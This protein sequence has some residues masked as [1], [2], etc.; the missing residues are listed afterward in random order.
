MAAVAGVTSLLSSG[1]HI[2]ASRDIYGGTHRLLT[3]LLAKYRIST[4]FVDSSDP[5]A[6][7]RVIQN[8]TR[9]LLLETPSNPTLKLT[10]IKA[11]V[12]R[13]RP[14]QVIAVD[15][16]FASPFFQKPLALGADVVFHSTTK[17]LCGHSDV[18]GGIVITDDPEI[19]QLIAYHQNCFGAIPGPWDS[20]LTLRGAKTLALRMRAHESNAQAI[21]EYLWDRFDV[22]DVYYPG[23]PLHPQHELAR[24]QMQGFGGIVSFRPRGGPKRAYEIARATNV[25]ALAVSLGGVESLI[26]HPA[27]MTHGSLSPHERHLLSIPDDLLRLSVGVEDIDD[28]LRDL[29]AALDGTLVPAAFKVAS[30]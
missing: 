18:V 30:S 4:T 13:K 9:M 7:S 21:A 15:N 24:R 29:T 5:D 17:Y 11:I 2:V 3:M 25:F 27:T 1:D 26:C 8:N 20:Y 10:D 22:D 23:L 16:T 12:A 28:L 14:G 19:H 6:V